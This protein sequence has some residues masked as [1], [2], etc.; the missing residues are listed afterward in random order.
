MEKLKHSSSSC[1]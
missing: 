1:W